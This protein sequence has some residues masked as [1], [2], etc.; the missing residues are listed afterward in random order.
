MPSPR[1]LLLPFLGAAIAGGAVNHATAQTRGKIPCN[2]QGGFYLNQAIFTSHCAQL[3]LV[4]SA[5]W[6]FLP[7]DLGAGASAMLNDP[8]NINTHAANP[9]DPWSNGTVNT[10]PTALNNV[11]FTANT[12]PLGALTPRGVNGLTFASAAGNASDVLL[13][14]TVAA[15]SFAIVCEAPSDRI[16]DAIAL[17]IVGP[18]T[19]SA[20][21]YSRY[22]RQV[23]LSGRLPTLNVPAGQQAFLGV[24]KHR[25]VR[26]DMWN[27]VSGAENIR[28]VT[29]YRRPYYRDLA[30]NDGVAD[31]NDL[32]AVITQWGPCP[33]DP[34]PCAA[35]V[36]DDNT[37]SVNDLLAIITAWGPLPFATCLGEDPSFRSCASNLNCTFPDF[38]DDS[39]CVP[40]ACSCV[41]IP[42]AASGG[43]VP[44]NWLYTDDCCWLCHS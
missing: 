12:T 4:E 16:C 43:T 15:D 39:F 9:S 5:S 44:G 33:P 26:V 7:H 20:V 14:P 3:G 21:V 10:W 18:A 6:T 35:D 17:Q 41:P 29:L 22:D 13:K 24:I 42:G 27:T 31:V 28:A 1:S 30:G 37:V 2:S 11:Q 34:A 23:V 32:L 8:L 25:M 38:C 40:S 19:I 36:N